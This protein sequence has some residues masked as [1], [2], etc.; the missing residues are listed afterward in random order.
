MTNL[1][2]PV[3]AEGEIITYSDNWKSLPFL[4]AEAMQL[5]MAERVFSADTLDAAMEPLSKPLKLEQFAGT[6]VVVHAAWLAESDV[7]EAKLKV[8]ALIDLEDELGNRKIVSNGSAQVISV[9][10]RAAAEDKLPLPARVVQ[11]QANK[12]WKHD[13][14]YLVRRTRAGDETF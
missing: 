6:D 3:N 13:P 11:G 10:A 1:P 7:P 14:Y 9:I 4:D 2:Q 5:Q 12:Q 8:Y